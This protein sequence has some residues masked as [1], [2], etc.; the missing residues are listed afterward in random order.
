MSHSDNKINDVLITA[1]TKKGNG[2]GLDQKTGSKTVEVPFTAPG[3]LVQAELSRKRSGVYQ[4]HLKEVI[5]PSPLRQPAKCRH[6][7]V[8]GG[9]RWQHISYAEQLK[10]KEET[11]K[12][13]FLPLLDLETQFYPIEPCVSPWQYRNKMEFS[14]SSD[15]KGERYL[16]LIMD[17][18][19]GKVLNLSE[20]HLVNPWYID[21]L[22]AVRDWWEDEELAAYHL[23]KNTGALRTL[24]VREGIRTGDRMVMLT[25]SGNPDFALKQAELD[26]FVRTIQKAMGTFA[27]NLSILLRIQQIAK[28][29]ETQFFEILLLGKDQIEEKLLVQNDPTVPPKLFSFD[30]GPTSFFQ[31]NTLQAERLYGLAI[32]HLNITQKDAVV[33]DLYCGTGTLGICVAGL[34]AR[35]IGIEIV[36]E[37]AIDARANAAKNGFP[38]IEILTGAVDEVMRSEAF[39]LVP[40]PDIVMVDPPRVG[41]DPTTIAALGALKPQKI[42]YISCN[43]VTQVQNITALKPFGYRLEVV[44]PV[45]QFPQTVHIE[46]I[47]ILSLMCP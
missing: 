9:C 23:S 6:F 11:V 5:T 46:N 27:G 29:R 31:P 20:C 14:F 3:D 42:L 33:Y 36:P 22:T 19:G 35:V 1:W 39:K 7:G 4:A 24:T 45:D 44:H 21:V 18:S 38:D 34:A 32:Q 40:P 15:A 37:A 12:A 10:I 13:L 28:G 2:S 41:L 17:S 25:V 26:S 43:P 16:G 30:V 8:C 47:A